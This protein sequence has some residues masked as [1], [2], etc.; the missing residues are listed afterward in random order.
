MLEEYRCQWR[1]VRVERIQNGRCL[2]GKLLSSND[3]SNDAAQCLIA[4][5]L[6]RQS[7]RSMITFIVS[8]DGILPLSWGRQATKYEFQ[9]SAVQ[10]D[11]QNDVQSQRKRER[12]TTFFSFR[13][14]SLGSSFPWILGDTRKYRESTLGAALETQLETQLDTKLDDTI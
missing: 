14:I 1:E 12:E 13:L 4:S 3:L 6:P 11:F 10:N 5:R 8:K 7:R 2:C 9:E